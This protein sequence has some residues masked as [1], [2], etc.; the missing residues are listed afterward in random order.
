MTDMFRLDGKV[1]V[2]M[3]VQEVSVKLWP[4]DWPNREQK[5]WWRVEVS[6]N[7]RP[8]L[9]RSKMRRNQRLRLPS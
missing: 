9:K 3:G 6:K 7:C 8:L 4:L 2:V 5:W 1:A